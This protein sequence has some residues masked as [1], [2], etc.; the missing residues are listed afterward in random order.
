[1]EFGGTEI[2]VGRI[3]F[4]ELANS[5]IAEQDTAAA[6]RLQS[7]L[8]RVDHDGV[9]FTDFRERRLCI[10]IES[11]SEHE[12]AA[13]GRVGMDAEAEFLAQRKDFRQG[14]DRAGRGSSHR[15]DH[16]ANVTAG[17]APFEGV[18]VHA[19]TRVH[20]YRL[21]LELQYAAG[22]L[23]GV[24]SLLAGQDFLARLLLTSGPQRFEIRY[25]AA[26]T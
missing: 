19:P 16:R 7:M 24:M 22:A 6:I 2:S 8:V 17:Q 14:I 4:V 15:C 25:G 10:F 3:L 12:V 1:M 23:V 9:D 18:N 21:K 13:V 5:G 11:P 20:G 26:T